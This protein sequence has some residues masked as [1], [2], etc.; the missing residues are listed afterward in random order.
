MNIAHGVKT[1]K[2]YSLYVLL[3]LIAFFPCL[4]LGQAYYANDLIYQFGPFRQFL[5]DQLLQG[6]F[7][8]WNPYLYGG[9]PFFANPNSMMCYPLNYLTLF[10][11]TAYGM[12][13]FYFL[14]MAIAGAGM[15]VWLKTLRLSDNAVRVG[16]L[17][18]A[19]SGFFWWELIHLHILADYAMFPVLM[20]TLEKL[21]QHWA[22]RWAFAA[23]LVFAVIFDCGSFQ[24]TSWILYTALTYVLFR[25]FFREH[26]EHS[27]DP[28]AAPVTWKKAALVL[29]FAFWGTLPLFVHLIPAK[30]F[31]DLSNRRSQGQ[32]Y[33]NFNGTFSM[34]PYTIYEF[35]FPTLGVA[36]GD[37]IEN[38]IQVISDQVNIGNDFLANFGYI[39]VW[40]PFFFFFAFGRKE[41]KFLYFISAAGIFSIL[42]AWGRFF[43][44]H[45]LLCDYLPTIDLSRAPFRFVESYV[46]FGCVL[47]A[48]GFQTLERRLE[49][50]RKS[51]GLLL[52]ASAYA[53]LLLV[54]SFSRP[55][56]AWREIT[57]LLLG[58]FGMNLWGLTR[59][60]KTL[61][62]W[63]LMTALILPLLLT[64]WNG[65]K[66]APS[67]N[68]NFE[69]NFPSFLSLHK[70]PT[71]IRYYFDRSLVY[72]IH[73]SDQV[74]E[75]PFPENTIVP[76]KIKDLGGYSPIVLSIFTE[77]HG[78][79]IKN[80]MAL[81]AVNGMLFGKNEGEQ[82]DYIHE[83]LQSS[84]LYLKKNP[85]PYVNAPNEVQID[86]DHLS[87]LNRL[88]LPDFNPA[89]QVFFEKSLPVSITSLLSKDKARMSYQLKKDDGDWQTYS[90]QLDK[91]S[92]VTFS[93]MVY[94][95]WKALVDGQPA[96]IYTGNNAF[97]TLFLTAG[98]H[99][100]DFKYQPSWFYP[101]IGCLG[102]WIISALVYGVW[103]YAS[104]EPKPIQ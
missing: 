22:P 81:L 48:Y 21:R 61:G 25:L 78:L 103:L 90:V 100:V 91:N 44:L 6:H 39:G 14:H 8:L 26:P 27:T 47:L 87:L 93:E 49:E 85:S 35:L 101:L 55:D 75:I 31:S 99:Q 3:A 102:L 36:Q 43:P 54:I 77:L 7:P 5:K 41:K 82:P 69:D 12:S 83:D 88:G 58:L 40:V 24:S 45:R 63:T 65:F 19:L 38:A 13:L 94:P 62:R 50:N 1:L 30:E 68:F 95:G 16:A 42:T 64:G 33:D 29:L 66:T 51:T 37:T 84:H 56:Q 97:R 32:T 52:A 104:R 34:K 10:L 86:P 73:G 76:E 28:A 70:E 92:L 79:P 17:T 46:L 9:Q 23:G 72:P 60:W 98:T 89:N 59:S 11:P 96:E 74:D 67:S 4:F 20:A 57:A 15:H 53:I 2:P 18:Y 80:Q 71:D